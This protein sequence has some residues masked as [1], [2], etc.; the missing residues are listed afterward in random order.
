M[1]TILSVSRDGKT[2]MGG[3]GQAT[4]GN[5]IIKTNCEK[6]KYMYNN[7]IIA[8]FAGSISD[9]FKLFEIFEKKLE[10][11]NGKLI[12]AAIDLAKDWRDDKILRR[13]E[14]FLAVANKTNSLIITGLGDIIKPEHNLIGI[15]SGGIYA[16]AAARVLLENTKLSAR[17]IV[18]KSLKIASDI[19]IYTNKN[20][21]IKELK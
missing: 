11:N 21:I 19:C 15:G 7:K 18:E 2:A 14:T 17:I 3:D 6:V 16:L 20:I 12:K 13:L 9:S 8:G 5:I 10:I 1:T 4:L